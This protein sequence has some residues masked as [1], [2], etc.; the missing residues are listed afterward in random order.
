MVGTAIALAFN[1]VFLIGQRK[2]AILALSPEEPDTAKKIE[3]FFIGAGQRWGA[4]K[5]V[6]S[7]VIFGVNHAVEVIHDHFEPQGA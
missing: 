6:I 3:G 7:K 2:R 5:D 1:A 4:R